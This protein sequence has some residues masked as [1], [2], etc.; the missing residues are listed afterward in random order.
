MNVFYQRVGRVTY[1]IPDP[2]VLLLLA[3]LCFAIGKVHGQIR[4]DQITFSMDTT[5][6]EDNDGFFEM[7]WVLRGKAIGC[8]T[9]P[10][11]FSL[12]ATE[13]DTLFYKVRQT[14]SWDTILCFLREPGNY[15]FVYNP[16]CGG[17]Y[18]KDEKSITRQPIQ[19]GTKKSDKKSYLG[20]LDNDGCMVSRGLSD[21]VKIQCR[22]VLHSNIYSVSL[23]EVE[24]V[25]F[26][27][28]DSTVSEV[29]LGLKTEQ[30]MELR[31]YHLLSRKF[32]FLLMPLGHSSLQI[33]YDA[34]SGK[35]NF[36]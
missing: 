12:K 9:G 36:R 15:K 6:M 31:N 11:G 4:P 8:Y 34:R 32:H 18:V 35:V 10:V 28:E 17:F 27:E 20:L 23:N 2:G 1:F 25:E 24:F 3:G 16:C 30:G 5:R 7:E 33:W 14:G 21:T 19:F 22:S 29:C 26:S 13:P